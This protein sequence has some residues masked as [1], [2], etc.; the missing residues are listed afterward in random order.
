VTKVRNELLL[1]DSVS[2]IVKIKTIP[3]GHLVIII[4]Q[5]IGPVASW[6]PVTKDTRESTLKKNSRTTFVTVHFILDYFY[7]K[8]RCI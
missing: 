7:F 5:F 4:R 3:G 2:T 6:F 8:L 1:C